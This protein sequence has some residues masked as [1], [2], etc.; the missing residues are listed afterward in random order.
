MR[1]KSA[2]RLST[3]ITTTSALPSQKMNYFPSS[4]RVRTSKCGDTL[5]WLGIDVGLNSFNGWGVTALDSL[6]T[7][8]IME[9]DDELDRAIAH[10]KELDILSTVREC[11]FSRLTHHLRRGAGYRRHQCPSL[12]RLFGTAQPRDAVEISL[13]ASFQL[14]WGFPCCLASNRRS[15]AS[16]S[17]GPIRHSPSTRI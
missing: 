9:L 15:S 3:R 11:H 14:S 13:N 5:V 2:P 12:R 16:P 8:Y 10:L 6:D 4:I 17:R 1:R 7:M